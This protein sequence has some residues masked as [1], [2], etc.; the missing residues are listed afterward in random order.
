M[1]RLL[2]I[3]PLLQE[4]VKLLS[5]IGGMAD[6]FF[7]EDELQYE[8]S[9]LLGKVFA[10]RPADAAQALNRVAERIER[11][12]AWEHEALEAAI[13]PLAEELEMKAGQLF[14]LVRVAVTGK[15]AAPPLFETMAVLGRDV[16]GKRLEFALT[17]LQAAVS[18]SR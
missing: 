15:A 18:Q 12:T 11:V 10:D 14:G 2:P 1:D 7:A 17:K 13:R 16:V 5:E 9:M 8:V 6:F 3:M 4:R